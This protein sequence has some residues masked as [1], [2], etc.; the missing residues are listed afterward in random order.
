MAVSISHHYPE[1]YLEIRW[2]TLAIE[3]KVKRVPAYDVGTDE[4][5]I[6]NEKRKQEN[7]LLRKKMR[8]TGFDV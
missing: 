6:Q 8:N 3:S 4:F 1:V 5:V 7:L 2:K